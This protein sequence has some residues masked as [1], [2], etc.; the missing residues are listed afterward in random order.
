MRP[1]SISVP[2]KLTP[3][4][5]QDRDELSVRVFQTLTVD[6]YA[7]AD[8]RAAC[9]VTTVAMESTGVSW[10]PVYEILEAR[11]LAVH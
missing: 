11:G 1:A 4:G 8:W 3:V 10:I 2:L 9:G 6:L 7:L 5:L